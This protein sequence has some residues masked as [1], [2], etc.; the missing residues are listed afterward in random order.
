LM[1]SRNY[2]NGCK[3]RKFKW[4]KRRSIWQRSDLPVLACPAIH[5][6]SIIVLLLLHLYSFWWFSSQVGT[7][8]LHISLPL[9]S[10]EY[11]V[12]DSSPP[13]IDCSSCPSS[14]CRP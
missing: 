2:A 8:P 9:E 6:D 14:T 5:F 1:F 12:I 11:H 3:W 10:L 4:W 13:M 7:I